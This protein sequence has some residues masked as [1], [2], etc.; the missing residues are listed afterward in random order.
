[1][2]EA[3]AASE[4][5]TCRKLIGLIA[6]ETF[7]DDMQDLRDVSDDC[8]A[9]MHGAMTAAHFTFYRLLF[10]LRMLGCAGRI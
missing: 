9:R 8:L 2:L 5:R 4:Y 6:S 7:Y 3:E 10:Q 1:M